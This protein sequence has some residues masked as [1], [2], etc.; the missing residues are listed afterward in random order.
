MFCKHLN[1]FNV[2]NVLMFTGMYTDP[3]Q[4]ESI[5]SDMNLPVN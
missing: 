2:S 1:H 5:F 3:T 4:T